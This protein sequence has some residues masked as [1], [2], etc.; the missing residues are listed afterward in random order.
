MNDEP[1][2]KRSTC[3][4]HHAP[5]QQTPTL[6]Q[7]KGRGPPSPDIPVK[8]H[9]ILVRSSARLRHSGRWEVRG[10]SPVDGT[11]RDCWR[12]PVGLRLHWAA[13]CALCCTAREPT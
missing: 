5:K 10:S 13:P 2:Q 7:A 9:P 6:D 4:A 12:T 1:C 11:Q 3:T 8:I